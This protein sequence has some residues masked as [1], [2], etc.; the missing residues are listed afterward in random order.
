M[1]ALPRSGHPA[2]TT[3]KIQR[4]MISEVKRRVT[5]KGSK[6]SLELVQL[7]SPQHDWDNV[8]WLF[9]LRLNCWGETC[10]STSRVK[11]AL[12]QDEIIIQEVKDGGDSIRIRIEREF[13]QTHDITDVN[14]LRNENGQK[15][16]LMQLRQGVNK[17]LRLQVVWFHHFSF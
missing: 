1:A 7:D 13:R 11:P 14:V 9:T 4:R 10:S 17:E 2:E 16:V 8:L 3:P 15:N 5:A 12:H 6:E